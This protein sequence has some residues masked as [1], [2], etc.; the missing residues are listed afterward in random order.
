MDAPPTPVLVIEPGS[1]PWRQYARDLLHH[2]DLIR[3]LGFR[4]IKLRYRQTALGVAW[5][6]LQPL[7]SAG[8]LGFVFNRV[9]RLPTDGVP[10]FAFTFAGFLAWTVFSSSLM[11]TT[12]SIVANASLVS[13]IFFPRVMLPLSALVAVT[14]DFL[15]GYFVLL[16]VLAGSHLLPNARL[17]LLPVWVL[18][19]MMLSQGVGS[20]LATFSVRY[21]DIPQVTPVLVQL[22]L[23]ASPVAYS[24]SAVPTRY[25]TIYELNPLAS[26]LG[27][28][29]W[30]VLGTP[31]PSTGPLMGA[32]VASVAALGIG[33]VVLERKESTFADV[34]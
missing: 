24:I 7:L 11:R 6:V 4:E 20:V 30:S 1:A 32:L 2:R 21:R 19:L 3:V 12:L 9:A 17:L 16:L 26:L 33:W 29:R 10:A 31:F 34:I 15:V 28:F 18:S 27:A 8:I 5:V 14:V 13:K 25:R 22:L 23:Y